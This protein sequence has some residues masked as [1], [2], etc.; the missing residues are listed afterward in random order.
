MRNG[1]ERVAFAEP[2]VKRRR[3]AARIASR[4]RHG[5]VAP[6]SVAPI[7]V[8]PI[9]VA[10]ISVAPISIAPISIAPMTIPEVRCPSSSGPD[11]SIVPAGPALA[12]RRGL[13]GA[14]HQ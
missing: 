12:S 13:R 4:P 14:N 10:P 1:R 5:S 2:A 7:S 3:N 6:I 11:L 8:A 9:S